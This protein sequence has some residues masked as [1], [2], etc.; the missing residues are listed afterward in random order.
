VGINLAVQDA[1][2][3]ANILA[4]PLRAGAVS[5]HDLQRVERRRLFPTRTT[6]AMQVLAQQRIIDRVLGRPQPVRPP[7]LLRLLDRTPWLQ[8]IPAQLLGIGVRP[9]HVRTREAVQG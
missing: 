1:V 4:D 9:E 5:D 3:A 7:A 6:Q 8:R 2:A